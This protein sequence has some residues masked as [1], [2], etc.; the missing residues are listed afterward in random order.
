MAG[1]AF[2]FQ[3]NLQHQSDIDD[4]DPMLLSSCR[5]KLMAQRFHLG[6]LLSQMEALSPSRIMVF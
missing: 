2:D 4:T 5:E 6:A 3:G 1:C